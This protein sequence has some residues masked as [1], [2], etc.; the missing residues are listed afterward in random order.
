MTKII[1]FI[2]KNWFLIAMVLVA[3]FF[4]PLLFK[5]PRR[6]RHRRA[7]VRRAIRIKRAR[8]RKGKSKRSS[9]SFSRRIGNKVYRSPKSWARAMQDLRKK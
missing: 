1:D 6:R 7:V 5:K 9:G 8:R 3:V 4:L 2:K